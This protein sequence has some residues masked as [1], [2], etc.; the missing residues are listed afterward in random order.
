MILQGSIET[1]RWEPLPSLASAVPSYDD[2]A[3][4]PV[5]IDGTRNLDV[6]LFEARV[7]VLRVFFMCLLLCVVCAA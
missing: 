4:P 2:P 7:L 5:E 3:Q 1:Q 6:P